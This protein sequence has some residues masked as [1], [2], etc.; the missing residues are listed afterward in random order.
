MKLNIF[1]TNLYTIIT[2]YQVDPFLQLVDDCKLQAVNTG[3]DRKVYGSKED[4]EDALKS[5]SAIEI[6]DTQSKESF[7][8][9]IAK[10][11]GM[12]SDVTIICILMI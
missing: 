9:M 7:A 12:S 1:L 10:F 8:A 2:S 4:D 6:V 5:L 11:L 3:L